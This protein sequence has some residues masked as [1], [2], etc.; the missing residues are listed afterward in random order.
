MFEFEVLVSVTCIIMFYNTTIRAIYKING[1]KKVIKRFKK[2]FGVCEHDYMLM[3]DIWLADRNDEFYVS[4]IGY[5]S[6]NYYEYEVYFCT[7]C[8]KFNRIKTSRV[9]LCEWN[10]EP[11][12]ETYVSMEEIEYMMK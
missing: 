8:T 6:V 2:L 3:S 12:G 11:K 4:K 7:E 10:S 9:R 1:G 5:G